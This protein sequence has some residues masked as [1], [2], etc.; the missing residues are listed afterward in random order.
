M[1]SPIRILYIDD[2]PFDRELVREALKK[3][4]EC[5]K[6]S[7]AK[8][9][10]ELKMM[11]KK[12]KFDL[13][14]SDLDI[15]GYN[16]LEIIDYIKAKKL[17]IPLVIVTGTG[18]E[19]IAVEAMKRGVADY[20]IKTP[21]HIKRLPLTIKSVIE[22]KHLQDKQKRAEKQ[23]RQSLKEKK[24][25]L[26]EIHHRV[27]NNLQI[28]SSLL[29][30]AG[31]QIHNK[32]IKAIC[33]GAKARIHTMAMIHNILYERKRF[34]KIN[35]K[36]YI[37]QLLAY[38]L[39]IYRTEKCPIEYKINCPRLYLPSNNAI[40]VAL[41]LNEIISNALKYDF[42]K[43]DKGEIIIT[44]K[45]SEKNTIYFSIMDNGIGIPEDFD[46]NKTSSLGMRLINSLVKDQL[47]GTLEIKKEKGTEFII[48]FRITNNY[49]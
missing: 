8:T 25:L 37:Q 2:Y 44:V 6:V 19:E 26:S 10:A 17:A 23:T 4:G 24:V 31:D 42:K 45:K 39:Q 27:R 30:F 1:T 29:S 18:S 9:H 32:K 41:I 46:I 13:I 5:F 40:H 48:K 34:D 22:K 36:K 33:E 21:D 16:G 35:M 15:L 11:L 12:R 7:V 47:K 28:I 43:G 20:V 14:L 49:L 3:T 38:L